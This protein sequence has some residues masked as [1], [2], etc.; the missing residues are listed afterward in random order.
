MNQS[1]KN[2]AL[3]IKISINGRLGGSEMTRKLTY[4]KGKMPL[5]TIKSNIE[6]GFVTATTSYGQN[7]IKV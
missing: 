5:S 2:G 6:Y 1:I 4:R 7:G 3:G